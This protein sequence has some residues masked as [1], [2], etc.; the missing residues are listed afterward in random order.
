MSRPLAGVLLFLG[1]VSLAACGAKITREPV[2]A[3]ANDYVPTDRLR[4][5]LAPLGPVD[6]PTSRVISAR[7]VQGLQQTH[8]DVALIASSD[9][10]AALAEARAANAPFLVSP[11]VLEWTDGTAPP[12]TVDRIKVRLDLLDT[13]AGEVVNAIVFENQ[14]SFTV[15]NEPPA[16]LLDRSFDTAVTRLMTPGSPR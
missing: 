16:T 13:R 4:V 6:E 15:F 3:V 9:R 2:G 1:A 8:A 10:T 14:T 7:I 12:F 5:M 11:T